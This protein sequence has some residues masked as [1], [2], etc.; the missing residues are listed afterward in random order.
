MADAVTCIEVGRAVRREPLG[1]AGAAA[2]AEE[3][4]AAIRVHRPSA[5][6]V[7]ASVHH[8][9][10]GVLGGVRRVVGDVPILGTTTAGE[11]CDGVH[12]Q[13]VV[14][15]VLASPYLSVR[16]GVGADVARDWVAAVEAATAAPG[17]REFFGPSPT[18]WQRLAREA[19]SAFAVVLSPGATQRAETKGFPIVELLKRRSLGRL[20]IF[21]MSASDEMQF[22]QNFVLAGERVVPDGLLV[23]VFETQLRFG[24]AVAHGFHPTGR[25]A[26]VT[27]ADDNEV[28][29]LDGRPAADVYAELI[30]VP[31]AQLDGVF[32]ARTTRTLVGIPGALGAFIPNAATYVTPRG[33]LRFAI[34][35]PPGQSVSRI[36][37]GPETP[38]AAGPE[39]LA[40]A[41]ARGGISR[42]AV[43]VTCSCAIRPLL[44]GDR[45]G[46]EVPAMVA[47]LQGAPLVGMVS[48]GEVGPTDDGVPQHMNAVIGALVLGD[49]LT[50]AAQV[51]RENEE[52]RRRGEAIHRQSRAEL[53]RLVGERTSQLEAANAQ[54]R[55]EIE[56]RRRLQRAWRTLSESNAAVARAS[57]E[58]AL[59]AEICRILVEVGGYRLSW[60]AYRTTDDRSEVLA[61]AGHDDGYLD[62]V[63][64]KHA[65][66]GLPPSIRRTLDAGQV[67]VVRNMR[68]SPEL[69]AWRDTAIQRGFASMAVLPLTAEGRAFGGLTIYA[70]E[71]N[72]LDGPEI[73]LL[74]DLAGNLALGVSAL[75]D[76]AERARMTAQLVQAD[77]L[78]AMGTLAAGVGHEIN[79]PLS[80][81]ASGLTTLSELIA[82]GLR[83]PER[84]PEALGIARE[85]SQG[86]E[87]IRL[88]VRDL[89]LFSARSDGEARR[90]LDVQAVL[91]ATLRLAHNDIRHRARLVRAY[92]PTPPVSASEAQLGQVFLNLI[93]HACASI[94]DG[95]ADRNELR[96]VT[97]TDARGWAAVEVHDTGPGLSAEDRTRV[98]EPFAGPPA[99]RESGLGLAV[100]RSVVL[101]MGGEISAE[102]EPGRGTVF[103]VAFPASLARGA[104]GPAEPSTPT[105]PPPGPA[106]GARRARVLVIDDEPLVARSVMRMLARE[107]DVALETS[108]AAALARIQAGERFDVVLCDV[109]MPQ[110]SGPEFHAELL[111]SHPDQAKRVVFITGGAFTPGA[112]SYLDEVGN[113]VLEKPFEAEDVRRLVLELL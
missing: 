57:D 97:G 15:A 88:T 32:V 14:V 4:L 111:R 30:D 103:R 91:E 51:A 35:I 106:P 27:A 95:A 34:P 46:E 74:S 40:K 22:E 39:A 75:R 79:N 56:E 84:I 86:L 38:T 24:I 21:G 31:R 77:R 92:G 55:A 20:P 41:V 70:G 64:R 49:E 54:L 90:P 72:A 10:Q 78:V 6:L 93:L 13:S 102:A 11:I 45:Q 76:R 98:F 68:T 65:S 100:C 16:V 71:P 28:V 69:G 82:G 33:G 112:A 80:F 9:L 81:A 12:H 85:V 37:A 23:A 108:S 83:E 113:R 50:P 63:L 19:R 5:A 47:A 60:V 42:P 66:E 1:A 73:A 94:P 61:S 53:E 62:A 96:V 52:L 8:D 3:A 87:R 67:Y 25:S 101:S 105:P 36:E 48:C 89:K 26:L 2:A 43:A 17:L 107:H 99:L 18:A 110:L 29:Q 59:Y 109:M 7:F 44:V 58:R 104:G